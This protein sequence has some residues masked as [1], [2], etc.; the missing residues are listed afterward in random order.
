MLSEIQFGLFLVFFKLKT[1]DNL[2]VD[3]INLLICPMLQRLKLVPLSRG[4]L[5]STL[6]GNLN[7]YEVNGSTTV[8]EKHPCKIHF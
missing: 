2:Y 8:V 3:K 4:G 7:T 6:P 1:L 5:I